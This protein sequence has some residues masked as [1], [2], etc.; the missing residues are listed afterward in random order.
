LPLIG[1]GNLSLGGTGKSPHT[2]YLL[3]LLGPEYTM[4]VLSRGYKRKTSGYV[5]A[6]EQSTVDQIG[7]EPLQM[8]LK[9]PNVAVA[10]GENRVMA[11]PKMLIDNKDTQVIVLDD[12]FQHRYITPGFLLLLTD[13]NNRY[14]KDALIPAGLLRES[15]RGAKRANV[16]IVTKCPVNMS[17]TEKEQIEAEMAIQPNQQLF[18]SNFKYG[19]PYSLTNGTEKLSGF[20]GDVLLVSGI[21]RP[22]YLKEALEE[23][24]GPTFL[25]DYPDHYAYKERDIY[26]IQRAFENLGEGKKAII[27]TEKDAVKLL[28]FTPTLWMGIILA[29]IC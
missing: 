10:V 14:T 19:L 12:V 8:K 2:E 11:V 9:Y 20:K 22:E 28:A 25:F 24:Y 21:A 23:Q 13:Y 16:I 15:K 27:V 1:I 3:D 17:I 6:N 18:F 26:D 29:N 5:F 7:D 4:G